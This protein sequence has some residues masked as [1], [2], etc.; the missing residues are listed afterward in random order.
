M[1]TSGF[2]DQG[3][4]I[5]GDEISFLHDYHYQHF[6]F[7]GYQIVGDEN[8]GDGNVS[9]EIISDKIIGDKKSAHHHDQQD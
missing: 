6:P 3:Y 8:V 5:V 9:D 4:Q 1:I 7:Y 2:F